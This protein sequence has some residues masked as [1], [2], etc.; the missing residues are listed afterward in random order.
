METTLLLDWQTDPVR[1]VRTVR[2]LATLTGTVAADAARVPLHL[3]LVIDR[4]GSMGGEPLEAAREAAVSVVQRLHPD[5]V[6][7]V[8]AFDDT[9]STVVPP[10]HGGLQPDIATDI[11]GIVEGGSTN[12]SGGWLRADALLRPFAREGTSTRIVLLTDGHANVG[13]TDAGQLAAL[14]QEA[15]RRGITT[16]TIGFGRGYD[17]DLLRTMAD[18]GG[19]NAWYIER[20]DQA[21]RVFAE[22][23]GDL[24]AL[25]A[26][27]VQVTLRLD[28][29]LQV[30]VHNDW[31][32][33]SSDDG[34]VLDLGDLYARDPKRVLAEFEV[35]DGMVA[36]HAMLGTLIVSAAVV[37]PQGIERRVT[38]TPITASMDAQQHIEPTIEREV[39][40][41][42]VAQARRRAVALGDAG[43][44]A[45][46]EAE[47]RRAAARCE[48]AERDAPE[49]RLVRE[50]L[51]SL[52]RKY[53]EHR[54]DEADRKYLKQRAYNAMRG[55][56]GYDV[57][58]SRAPEHDE[59]SEPKPGPRAPRR[60]RKQSPPTEP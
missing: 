49:L 56:L 6:V 43:D 47:L 9:A 34:L 26:Q 3:G 55:K 37:S 4:S 33:Q 24:Q 17:E 13:I 19:G 10:G 25:C 27:D 52:A 23:L 28:G 32:A 44:T 18:A 40:A 31:P 29:A 39:L 12:L 48:S 30:R 42:F 15:R 54:A 5:D 8:V 51:E 53:G 21:G 46:A 22:E 59:G 36:P 58:M 1:G 60:S 20:N 57:A 41:A 7:S 11:R 16:S 38:T 35:I 14:A 50:D 2:V 45:A